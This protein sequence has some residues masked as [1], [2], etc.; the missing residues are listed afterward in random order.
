MVFQKHSS[1]RIHIHFILH[2][3]WASQYILYEQ[4]KRLLSLSWL[5]PYNDTDS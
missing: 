2:I 3:Y 4:S 5:I 1:N